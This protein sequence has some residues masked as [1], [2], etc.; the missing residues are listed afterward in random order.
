MQVGLKFKVLTKSKE[1]IMLLRTRSSFDD[2]LFC[3][4]IAIINFINNLNNM[5]I[6][7]IVGMRRA[8]MWRVM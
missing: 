1:V 7:W 4:Y 6:M 3:E 5:L 2:Q 8:S